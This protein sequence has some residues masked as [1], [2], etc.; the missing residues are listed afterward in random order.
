MGAVLSTT[1]A[2]LGKMDSPTAAPPA[3]SAPLSTPA[4]PLPANDLRRSLKRKYEPLELVSAT[5]TP[6]I[7]AHHELSKSKKR[8]L[9]A[10]R[11]QLA[12]R[13]QAHA[14]S[15]QINALSAHS[16]SWIG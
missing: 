11:Q 5:A 4:P 16:N 2:P 1:P 10:N 8:K 15:T 3:A 12:L 7:P 13:L 14:A 9:R 6:D